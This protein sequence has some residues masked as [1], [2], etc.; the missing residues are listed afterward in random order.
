MGGIEFAGGGVLGSA[1]WVHYHQRSGAVAV[2][3]GSIPGRGEGRWVVQGEGGGVLPG[4]PITPSHPVGPLALPMTHF[5]PAP[6]PADPVAGEAPLRGA[7]LP[8]LD[9]A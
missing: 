9:R 6:F 3:P 2:G 8:R 4:R 7:S 1:R 5:P